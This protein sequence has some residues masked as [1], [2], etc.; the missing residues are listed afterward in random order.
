MRQC[1][2]V[3]AVERARVVIHGGLSQHVCDAL[4]TKFR[5]CRCTRSITELPVRF[6]GVPLRRPLDTLADQSDD[7]FRLALVAGLQT[8]ISLPQ[9]AYWRGSAQPQSQSSAARSAGR[10]RWML[11]SSTPCRCA[12]TIGFRC[13][14]SD[15]SRAR[16][17]AA[18]VAPTARASTAENAAPPW[19]SRDAR[20][21]ET[22]CS[23]ESR[24]ASPWETDRKTRAATRSTAHE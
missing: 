4:P 16:R 11:V 2:G 1:A 7:E 19:M 14:A 8:M 20:R 18:P 9:S 23:L 24:S 17:C 22:R 5:D 21:R 6:R 10:Q 13:S 3:V 15:V 12:G